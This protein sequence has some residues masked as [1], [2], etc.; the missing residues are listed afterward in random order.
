MDD[1]LVEEDRR[2]EIRIDFC[3]RLYFQTT[4]SP[5]DGHPQRKE[6]PSGQIQNVGRRGC[7]L[8]LDQ[9]LEKFR[10]I[11]LAFPLPQ[12][13]LSI[14]TL[15]EVRWVKPELEQDQY[16]VGVRYLL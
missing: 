8:I 11:K 2:Q 3:E 5:N 12:A 4:V 7:C 1:L 10:I 6:R 14:P 9:P 16:K 15:G 13:S